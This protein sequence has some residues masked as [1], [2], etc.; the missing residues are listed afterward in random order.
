VAAT[1]ISTDYKMAKLLNADKDMSLEG[2]SNL[3]IIHDVYKNIHDYTHFFISFTFSN[4]FVVFENGIRHFHILPNLDTR[5]FT[6]KE[7]IEKYKIFHEYYYRHMNVGFTDTL[8]DFYVDGIISMLKLYNKKYVIYTVEPRQTNFPSEVV[9]I[10]FEKY[11]QIDDGHLDEQGMQ[12]WAND[13]KR[14]LF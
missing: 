12:D 14:R 6:K 11:S 3:Q 9:Q 7:D 4:R 2:K 5:R 13:A 10:E 8:A 1:G